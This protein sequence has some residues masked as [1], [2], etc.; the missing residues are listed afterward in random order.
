M[1]D[2]KKQLQ[3]DRQ[4]IKHVLENHCNKP[5]RPTIV[6]L[7][8]STR[9]SDAYQRANLEETLAGKIVLTIGCDM[10]SDAHLFQSMSEAERQTIKSN[11]DNLHLRKIDEADEILVLN[12]GNYI[13][14]STKREIAYAKLAGKHIRYLVEP[15]TQTKK[16]FVHFNGRGEIQVSLVD[17]PSESTHYLNKYDQCERLGLLIFARMFFETAYEA[18]E[19]TRRHAKEADLMHQRI[20]LGL[21]CPVETE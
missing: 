10:K 6:C 12:V 14:D 17:S 16:W 18:W 20:F 11:L 7:C 8:G 2:F 3:E 1:T 4:A 19:Y 5:V 13:G 9:F 15:E 21:E